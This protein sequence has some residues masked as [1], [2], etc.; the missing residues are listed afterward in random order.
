MSAEEYLA[1]GLANFAMHELEY[2]MK[3]QSE[4][5][6]PRDINWRPVRFAVRDVILFN[7]VAR[8]QMKDNIIEVDVFL[9]YDPKAI[10]GWSGTKFAAIY[11]L[12]QA[13]KSGSSMG[14]RF[15]RNVEGGTVPVAI[16][17]MAEEYKVFLK[18]EHIDSG[19]I[20][21]RE[22]RLLYLALTEFGL[23]AQE[24]AMELS[25]ADKVSPERV[26]YMVNHETYTKDEM[27]TVLLGTEFPEH[28]LLG[29]VTPQ[30]SLL[31]HDI[32]LRGRDVVLG[33][34]LDRKLKLKEVAEP[35]GTVVDLEENDRQISISFDPRFFA[36]VYETQ[37]E[38][39]IPWT[40]HQD[41]KVP[42]EQ[43]LV[44]MVRAR[45]WADFQ[46]YFDQDLK[47][48]VE[49]KETYRDRPSYFLLLVPR[50]ILSL[51]SEELDRYRKILQ[52]VKIALMTCP[53]SV[54]LLDREVMDR[55]RECETMRHDIGS[56][57][58]RE[59]IKAVIPR[60]DFNSTEIALV[61]VPRDLQIR[62]LSL[63]QLTEQAVYDEEELRRG[64]NKH[65]VRARYHLVCDRMQFLAHQALLQNQFPSIALASDVLPFLSVLWKQIPGR[66]RQMRLLPS[67]W[68][69]EQTQAYIESLN[70]LSGQID[71]AVLRPVIDFLLLAYRNNQMVIAVQNKHA[72]QASDHLVNQDIVTVGHLTRAFVGQFVPDWINDYG[73]LPFDEIVVK[74][75][76]R[77]VSSASRGQAN[78]VNLSEVPHMIVTKALHQMVYERP[79]KDSSGEIAI[80]IVYTDGSQ[81]RPFPMFVL[82]S[83]S[84][85]AMQ[86]LRTIAPIRMGMISMRHPEMDSMVHQ[87]WF[88]NIEVSQPGMT[89]AEVDELCYQITLRKLGEIYRLNKPVRFEF[90][91]TGF[92]APLI[93]FWRAVVEFLKQ[94]QGRPPM[95]EIVPCFYMGTKR[96]SME[97]LNAI[98]TG[99]RPRVNYE[100]LYVRGDPWL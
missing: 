45:D 83:R 95:L 35:D 12:S 100:Q 58:G 53:E 78:G 47:A 84:D 2:G 49:M 74:H 88:R 66:V 87:Y 82:K 34:M 91:Q 99:R 27:E 57:E 68:V 44:V 62:R 50:D 8:L 6:Q 17:Q 31:Y 37:E 72:Q 77:A 64:V 33:G 56:G 67:F 25:L 3:L 15:T 39:P 26:C 80:N 43:R 86:Q 76:W 20:T 23:V 16:T 24:R 75:L 36:K 85:S 55:L 48:L 97:M 89:S 90:Y 46:S 1:N 14:I 29:K 28:L 79:P 73:N 19:V 59:E 98:R 21:P 52:E 63:S 42:A 30:E 96:D 93:G 61:A 4:G 40:A 22:A 92:Q 13:Y 70:L 65:N 51:P 94:G 41:W 81:A 18:K 11:I 71:I 69:Q 10:P 5:K 54:A 60:F 38:T 7:V 9:T 32:T